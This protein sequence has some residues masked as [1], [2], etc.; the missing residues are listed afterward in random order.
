MLNNLEDVFISEYD[1]V[2]CGNRKQNLDG[3][4]EILENNRK[5]FA[6]EL[7]YDDIEHCSRLM[8]EIYL[9]DTLLKC[10]CREM[11][12]RGYEF[13]KIIGENHCPILENI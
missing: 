1:E 13:G 9:G 8:I 4:I 7:G 2:Y 12:R 10:F 11:F 5:K 6:S 3:L